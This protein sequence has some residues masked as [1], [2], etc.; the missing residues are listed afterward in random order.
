MQK[1]LKLAFVWHMHQ[2]YYKDDKDGKTLFPWVFLH[3]I[4]D[5]YDMPWYASNFTTIKATYNLVPSLIEQINNYINNNANDILLQ[6]LKK[7]INNLSEEDIKLLESYLFLSNEKNM[8]KPLKRYYELYLK[9]KLNKTIKNFDY[10]EILDLEILFLL[11]WCGNFLRE[12][13]EVIKGL[14]KKASYYTNYDKDILLETLILF[15]PLVL[16]YY[17]KLQEDG[18]ISVCTTPYYHPITPLLLD[19]QNAIK[20][21]NNVELPSKLVSFKEYGIRNTKEAV[22]FYETIF[23]TK[24]NGFWPAEGSVSLDTANLFATNGLKWF[25]TDEEILFKTINNKDKKNIYKNYTLN[26]DDKN[27]DIRF[28]DHFL[29]DAIGFNYSNKDPKSSVDEFISHLE[30]IYIKCDFSPLVNIILDGENA[31]EFF[32]NNAKE[33]FFELYKKL[34]STPWIECVTQDEIKSDSQIENVKL[35][36]LASGSWIGGNFDTWIGQKDKNKAWELLTLTNENYLKIKDNLD[37]KTIKLVDREFMQALASDWFWWYGDDHYTIQAKEFDTLFRKHLINIYELLSLQIPKEILEPI[38]KDKQSKNFH[39][40]PESFIYPNI[41]GTKNNYFEWLHSGVV[42]MKKELSVMDGVKYIIENFLYGYHKG[43]LFFYIE[44][45]MLFDM[46]YSTKL[47]INIDDIEFEL[48]IKEGKQNILKNDIWCVSFSNQ[49]EM[50]IEF[51]SD[52]ITLGRNIKFEFKLLRDDKV[53]QSFPAYNDFFIKIE[54]L[55]LNL[56]N[57]FI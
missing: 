45:P 8:I 55:N 44:S 19:F 23:K 12:T 42:D 18:K 37:E 7:D 29:S 52:M 24:P 13:N 3:S 15:L 49:N 46:K 10:Q 5:Y 56:K 21:K 22:S 6:T 36:T 41:D 47:I 48:F 26:I 1:S 28:R 40:P 33:F 50:E 51:S 11:S 4:K 25:C 14:L 39:I 34:E 20:A 53:I 31:W 16:E 43:K 9:Y 35:N 57:W 54:N 27:I 38:V 30:E 2:P 32:P 17:K